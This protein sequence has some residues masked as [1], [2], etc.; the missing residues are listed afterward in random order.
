[1]VYT[2]L[3][4]ARQDFAES[5]SIIIRVVCALHWVCSEILGGGMPIVSSV[6]T[7]LLEV[8]EDEGVSSL[9]PE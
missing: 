5:C 4:V 8:G 2:L 7:E 9:V 3:G 1:V 6:Y